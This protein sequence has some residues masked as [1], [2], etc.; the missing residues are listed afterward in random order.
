MTLHKK[1]RFTLT[2]LL[3]LLAYGMCI[4][5]LFATNTILIPLVSFIVLFLSLYFLAIDLYPLRHRKIRIVV[6]LLTI[7]E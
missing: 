2:G 6:F 4:F 1:V 3:T 7:G 5:T